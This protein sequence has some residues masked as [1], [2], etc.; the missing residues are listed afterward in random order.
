MTDRPVIMSAPM[1]RAIL[2]EINAP[3]T[4]KNMT[5]RLLSSPLA[6]C[7]IGDQLWVREAA[8]IYTP[9]LG[10]GERVAYK[11]DPGGVQAWEGRHVS[12]IHLR[13]VDSR[14][15]LHVTEVHRERVQ[16]ITPA[17]C[18][19]EGVEISGMTVD[20]E[21][22]EPVLR[23]DYWRPFADLWDSLHKKPGTRWDDDPEVVV[24]GFRPLLANIDRIEVAA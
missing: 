7:E 3:G 23:H 1:V 16:D 20:M 12:P 24:L 4:G 22:G 9:L 18:I 19:A 17:D 15:T 8:F 2:R 13:R 14:L 6:K 10:I 11:A 5:R 21:T